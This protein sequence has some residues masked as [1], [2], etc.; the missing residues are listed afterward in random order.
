MNSTVGV[1]LITVIVMCMSWRLPAG[2]QETA[3]PTERTAASNASPIAAAGAILD[4]TQAANWARR[5]ASVLSMAAAGTAQDNTTPQAEPSPQGAPAR[6]RLHP[7]VKVRKPWTGARIAVLAA[8]IGATG[9][10]V[11]L[12][13]SGPTIK[14]AATTCVSSYNP[15][16][17]PNYSSCSG[18][19]TWSGKKKAG[20]GLTIVGASVSILAFV[21]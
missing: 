12:W 11:Y 3:L 10:G 19:T 13:A 15:F 21:W 7:R 4:V 18:P 16:G 5:N 17:V 2:A 20:L 14:P 9:A 6:P 1:R 8:G